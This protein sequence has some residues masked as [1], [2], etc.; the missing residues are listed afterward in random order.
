MDIKTN[1]YFSIKRSYS[2]E[3]EIQ[4]SRFIAN[5]ISVSSDYDVEKKLKKFIKT[6]ARH[7]PY[8]Y[9]FQE[10]G[11]LKV[12]AYDDGEPQMSSGMPIL[13]ML[14][15]RGMQNILCVVTRY[16]GGI[17]L[18]IG[19]LQQAYSKACQLAL[20]KAVIYE[21]IN[22]YYVNLVLTFSQ[23]AL[24]EKI[25]RECRVQETKKEFTNNVNLDLVIPT[26]KYTIFTTK[27]NDLTQGKNNLKIIKND[28]YAYKCNGDGALL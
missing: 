12:K 2:A 3:I 14:N 5:I 22:S 23:H 27:I 21:Y 8:A 9:T 15:G 19:G 20:D 17:K 18:G 11:V 26:N 6:D 16:Y 7:N 1:K 28:Y 24:Y 25:K 4:K 10:N 13:N